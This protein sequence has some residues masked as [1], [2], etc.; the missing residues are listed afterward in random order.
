MVENGLRQKHSPDQQVLSY[1]GGKWPVSEVLTRPAG[2]LLS[3]WKMACVRSTEQTSRFF[4]ILVENGL[5]QKYPP[6]Q[7]VLSYFGGKWPVSEVPSRPAGS[8]LFWWKMA[9]VRSTQ[10]TS[11][12]FPILVE[13]GLCQSTDQTSRFFPILVENGLCQKY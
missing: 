10:Q 5:C 3:W 7:Q 12:F 9:C 1:L 13:N 11:R 2:S 4:P 8:F 6:D